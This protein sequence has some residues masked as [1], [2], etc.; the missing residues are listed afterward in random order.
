MGISDPVLWSFAQLKKNPSAVI[1]AIIFF[2]SKHNLTLGVERLYRLID[3]R[4]FRQ[5]QLVSVTM[6]VK[7]QAGFLWRPLW[8]TRGCQ[9]AHSVTRKISVK[10]VKSASCLL[11][12]HTSGLAE[13][14]LFHSRINLVSFICSQEV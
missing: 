6:A 12:T 9:I 8:S 4:T 11:L 13:S 1:D 3:E 2:L 10:L 14:P 7:K 5:K